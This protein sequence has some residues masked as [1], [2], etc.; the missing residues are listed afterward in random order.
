MIALMSKV[1]QLSLFL[2][3]YNEQENI[4]RTVGDADNVLKKVAKEYEVLVVEDG[5]K[6]KTAQIVKDL[7]KKNKHI[8]MIQHK[9]NRGYGGAF[10]SGLYGSKSEL[11]SFI[12]SDGQ[13]DYSEVSKLLP[14]VGKYDLVIGYRIKR[15]DSPLRNLN[16]LLW[17]IWMWFLFGLWV[18]DIDC[19]FKVIKKHVIDDIT[20]ETESALTSAEFLIRVKQKGYRWKEVGV[21]HYPRKAGAATGANPKV[22]IR[23]FKESIKLWYTMNLA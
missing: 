21:H 17:K 12:D 23:A 18:K 4:A 14:H 3:T 13:F 7:M 20:L 15:Q 5:S 8:R 19:A 10:K 6:D 11:V 2:P 1:A 22:I 9:P 16:A